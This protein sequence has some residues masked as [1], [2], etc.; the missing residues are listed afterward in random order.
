M[1]NFAQTLRRKLIME[2]Q[3]PQDKQ[4]STMRHKVMLMLLSISIAVALPGLA[5]ARV[6]G[7]H[8]GGGHFASGH[9]GRLFTC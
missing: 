2:Q 3:G 9:G 8:G 6:G 5:E 7:G 1:S 4:E